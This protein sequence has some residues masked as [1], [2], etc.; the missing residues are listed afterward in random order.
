MKQG[1]GADSVRMQVQLIGASLS[2][3]LYLSLYLYHLCLYLY[4]L[5]LSFSSSMS[6]HHLSAG[7]P[8]ADLTCPVSFS[9]VALLP[10]LASCPSLHG[11]D[12]FTTS[13]PHSSQ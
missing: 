10:S 12:W 6:P 3:S 4:H 2:L 7:I 9:L 13:K 1:W 11:Q 5:Y 8:G